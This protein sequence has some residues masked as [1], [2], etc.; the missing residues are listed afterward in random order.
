MH[1][2]GIGRTEP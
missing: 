2:S 1:Y